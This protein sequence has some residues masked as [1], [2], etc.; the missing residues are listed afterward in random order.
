MRI[1][2]LAFRTDLALLQLGGSEVEDHESYVVVRTPD[3]PTY[4]WGNFLLLRTAPRTT[5]SE[6]GRRSSSTLPGAG[7]RA[8]AWRAPTGAGRPRRPGECRDVRRRLDR[9]DRHRD[10]VREPRRP[11]RAAT[12]RSLATDDDWQQQFDLSLAGEEHRVPVR[13]RQDRGAAAHRRVG[14]GDLVGAFLG[15]QLVLDGVFRAGPGC[16]GSRTSRRTRT[17]AA[18]G[19]AGTLIHEVSRVGV[20]VLGA[21]TLVIVADPDYRAIRVYRSVGFEDYETQLQAERETVSHAW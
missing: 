9:P 11:N 16:A 21:T 8:T 10:L 7:H 2:S 17:S 13:R 18:L 15:D 12:Y 14:A 6:D 1:E 20:E 4:R 19:L 5:R 3:N